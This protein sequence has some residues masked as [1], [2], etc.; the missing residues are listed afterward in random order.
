MEKYLK[1]VKAVGL[2]QGFKEDEIIA[3]LK[4]L[5]PN[6][7]VYSKDEA[8]ALQD[9]EIF[10]AG[11]IIG[12]K[13]TVQKEGV[14][15][16]LAILDE[17]LPGDIFGKSFIGAKTVKMP[18]SIWAVAQTTVIFFDYS[19]LFTTCP[20]NCEFHRKLIGNIF[21]SMSVKIISLNQKISV[22]KNST[23]R[24]KLTA[25]F[26]NRREA[27][28][29]DTFTIPL[30]RSELAEYIGANRSAVSRELNN[31]QN[32]GLIEVRGNVFRIMPF[33]Q[34]TENSHARRRPTRGT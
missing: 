13:A 9:D 2:F 29:S 32:D 11:I 19:R 16:N 7:T 6:F 22:M 25:Y 31:M 30:N 27:S 8:I 1:L 15:G 23:I 14:H 10:Q 12:G 20:A 21:E 33:S 26:E 28:G 5:S 24:G 18:A 4:C 3:M 34:Y 17:L